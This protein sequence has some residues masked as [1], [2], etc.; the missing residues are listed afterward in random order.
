MEQEKKRGK[1]WQF[2]LCGLAAGLANGLF[3][4]GGGMILVPLFG[5]W[6]GLEEKHAF[7]TSM[8]VMMPLCVVSL[9]V[10]LLRGGVEVGFAWRYLV[11]GVLGGVLSGPLFRR[12]PTLWLRRVMGVFLLYGGVRAVLLL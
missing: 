9:S 6:A 2:L 1:W 8:A 4:T 12:L 7:A 10:Y 5:G 3:G 11:G